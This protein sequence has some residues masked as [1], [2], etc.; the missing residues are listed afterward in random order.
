MVSH[1]DPGALRPT[2]MANGLD[3]ISSALGLLDGDPSEHDLK[4]AIL[5]LSAGLEIFLK[6]RLHREHWSLVFANVNKAS[7]PSLRSGDFQS[8]GI[9]DA[10]VRIDKILGLRATK[11]EQSSMAQLKVAR[12]MLEHFAAT[13]PPSAMKVQVIGVLAFVIKLLT[14]VV[15]AAE[16]PDLKVVAN[17]RRRLKAFTQYRDQL[18]DRL[19]PELSEWG[20]TREV[21]KCPVC[22]MPACCLGTE[23]QMPQ[24]RFCGHSGS[25][26][27]IADEYITRVLDL[28]YHETVKGGDS[29]PVYVCPDCD[30]PSLVHDRW[31]KQKEGFTCFAC[32]LFTGPD[33]MAF[34]AHC[35]E[36]FR[37]EMVVCDDCFSARITMDE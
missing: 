26:A 35:G 6:E 32:G 7:K 11:S 34:C 33:K 1:D 18:M 19:G 10:L 31:G 15:P 12:N 20:E 21:V 29:W 30:T 37:G 36:L 13:E 24:C 9:D 25:A 27:D 17:I 14:D 23:A 3:F 22:S 8:V 4:Y 5:H 28:S 16:P 2:L